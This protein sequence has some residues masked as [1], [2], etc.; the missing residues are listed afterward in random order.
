MIRFKLLIGALFLILLN[1]FAQ[2]KKNQHLISINSRFSKSQVDGILNDSYTFESQLATSG[3]IGYKYIRSINPNYGLETGIYSG[4]FRRKWY[5]HLEE[6]FIPF[7]G[8]DFMWEFSEYNL[9]FKIPISI[10]YKYKLNNSW[11]IKGAL[12]PHL[13]LYLDRGGSYFISIQPKDIAYQLIQIERDLY[14][15]ERM[16]YHIN[17]DLMHQ[18][19]PNKFIVYGI[20]FNDEFGENTLITATYNNNGE[21][22]L[23]KITHNSWYAGINVGFIF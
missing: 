14:G 8:K 22:A 7:W 21:L 12:G 11:S 18:F 20:N 10:S 6:S 13:L 19:R 5:I 16:G 1:S 15:Q 3:E 9:Y 17:L 23:A 4:I 2:E